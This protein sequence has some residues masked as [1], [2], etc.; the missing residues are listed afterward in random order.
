MGNLVELQI[1]VETEAKRLRNL[2]YFIRSDSFESFYES[3][4][5]PQKLEL[6]RLIKERNIVMLRRYVLAQRLDTTRA[7]REQAR[8]LNIKYYGLMDKDQLLTEI[9][10]REC[11][12]G[13]LTIE[14]IAVR[15]V[16]SDSTAAGKT[17]S[18]AVNHLQKG[19]DREGV[20]GKARTHYQLVKGVH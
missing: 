7:L 11:E 5:I 6:E 13:E 18:T 12:N 16:Q 4:S 15:D 19:E 10:N 2:H 1:R 17:S 9:A 3:C 14:G 8:L 20:N